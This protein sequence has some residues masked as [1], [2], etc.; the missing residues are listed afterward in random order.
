[1]TLTPRLDG[2]FHQAILMSGNPPTS[3][4]TGL[5]ESKIFAMAS[6]C[7]TELS[8]RQKE[9]GR[10]IRCLQSKRAL[11]LLK[12]QTTL[13]AS[14]VTS[15][16]PR[17]DG[18]VGFFPTQP[19]DLAEKRK[20]FPL[21]IGSVQ[22]EFAPLFTTR[23]PNLNITSDMVGMGCRLLL[24]LNGVP[25]SEM[26]KQTTACLQAYAGTWKDTKGAVQHLRNH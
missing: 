23:I 1:M 2:L 25:K 18:P 22:K 20:A 12:I 6:G 4:S 5:T 26:E 11:E 21:M 14:G 8:W 17:F 16:Q 10:I 19:D 13:E 3:L 9:F 7:A 24:S 15:G